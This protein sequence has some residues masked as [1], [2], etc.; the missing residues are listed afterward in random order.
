M[1]ADFPKTLSPEAMR[2]EINKCDYQKK[3]SLHG[4]KYHKQSITA[5]GKITDKRIFS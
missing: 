5:W 2:K 4:K 3:K 1:C